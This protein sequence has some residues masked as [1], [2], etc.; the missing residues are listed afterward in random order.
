M[1]KLLV[2]IVVLCLPILALGT[3]QISV[4]E[5][6]W[7]YGNVPQNGVL[8]HN[9]IVRNLGTDTLKIIQVRPG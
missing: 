9:Y 2:L 5:T 4:P 6:H 3:P 7:E 1:K 8:S